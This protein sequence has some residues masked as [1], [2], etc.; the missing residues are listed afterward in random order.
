MI[1]K[2]FLPQRLAAGRERRPKNALYAKIQKETQ[3]TVN[4]EQDK[5]REE[6][7][8]AEIRNQILLAERNTP[9]RRYC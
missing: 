3:A 1:G 2:L 7:I 8:Q 5:A 9:G 6:L 4:A